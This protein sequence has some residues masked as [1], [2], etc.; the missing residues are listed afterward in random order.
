MK[1]E[2]KGD[3]AIDVTGI[4]KNKQYNFE[5]F[6]VKIPRKTLLTKTNW[7]RTFKIY[8]STIKNIEAVVKH[9]RTKENKL[10]GRVA[11][12]LSSLQYSRDKGREM[13]TDGGGGRR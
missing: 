12:S 13:K 9:N 2:W 10:P 11:S 8:P 1:S 6:Q 7:R 4:K 3:V 5:R